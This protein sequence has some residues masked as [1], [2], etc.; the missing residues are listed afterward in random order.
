M[1]ACPVHVDP[2]TIPEV[3]HVC[4]RTEPPRRYEREKPATLLHEALKDSTGCL[5]VS[6]A[7]V[8]YPVYEWIKYRVSLEPEITGTQHTALQKV[9][10]PCHYMAGF[11]G[12]DS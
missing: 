1:V 6:P 9:E 5:S 3:K 12:V 8:L 4:C 11:D 2:A 7:I 10:K